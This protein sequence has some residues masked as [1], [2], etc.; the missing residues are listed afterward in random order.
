MMN[1]AD[2]SPASL[3]SIKRPL[4]ITV[5]AT[6]ILL[7]GFGSWALSSQ[8]AG[9][10][11]ASGR[12]EVADNR[13]VLQHPDG[14]VVAE[15][16]VDEG[17]DV[18]A[19]ELLLSLE[20]G[21]L[22]L[23]RKIINSRLFEVRVRRARLEA[24]R[25]GASTVLFATHLRDSAST[26]TELNE[27]LI[28]Q[29]SLFQARKDT[30]KSEAE[31]LQGRI[32]QIQAQVR[33]LASQEEALNE[34]ISLVD[35]ELDRQ[36]TLL[37]QGLSRSEPIVQ[38]KRDRA[39]LKGTLGEVLAR[40]AEAAERVIETELD[41]I[42]LTT[43][44]R[45]EAITELREIR[46]SEEE[47]RQQ[48]SDLDRRISELNIYAPVSGRILELSVLGPKSVVRPADPIV[49]MVPKGRDFIINAR[50]PA[51]HVDQVYAGQ[52]VVLRFP[53]FDLR[54]IPD[55]MGQVVQVSPDAFIDEQTGQS[56][57]KTEVSLSE[58]EQAKLED[59]ELLPGMP[60]EAFIR[61]RDRTPLSYF[62]EPV[63]VYFNRAFRES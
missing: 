62:L 9:A 4:I 3:W 61:T 21:Q 16:L 57:Y 33:A 54:S 37:E 39:E 28:G 50:V 46:V 58:T 36:T 23:E 11:V 51:I 14:G 6:V 53:A 55:L 47:L 44:R 5:A 25:D 35:A 2:T 26:D 1:A 40:R 42:Q 18:A 13:Q 41:I 49:S 34:Q 48:L 8:L 31:K 15:L 12:I 63:S 60:V 19:G 32:T 56:F 10:V 45:E 7:G 30:L 22:E 43:V 52:T 59:R 38:L 29:E 24:E 27:L 17:D 20:P